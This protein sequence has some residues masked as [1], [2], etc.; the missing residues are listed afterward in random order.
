M[1]YMNKLKKGLDFSVIILFV[2]AALF[3]WTT[4]TSSDKEPSYLNEYISSEWVVTEGESLWTIAAN[5]YENTNLSI[6]QT[7]VWMKS[8]NNLENESIFPGQTL[9]VP[10]QLTVYVSE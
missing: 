4:I 9:E 1:K 6:E 10:A 8:K 5:N 7:I 2:S 3:A